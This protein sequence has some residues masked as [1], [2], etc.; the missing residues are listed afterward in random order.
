MLLAGTNVAD[1]AVLQR[2]YAGRQIPIRQ[3]K[4]IWMPNFSPASRMDVAPSISTSLSEI[5]NVTVPPSPPLSVAAMLKR[6][7]CSASSMSLSCHTFSTA[8][9]MAAGPHAHAERSRQS[10]TMSSS[11]SNS[12]LPLVSVN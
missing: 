6:S 12:T 10:A 9:S 1:V 3:P 7:M 11:A 5:A 4:G 8:S 2:Q